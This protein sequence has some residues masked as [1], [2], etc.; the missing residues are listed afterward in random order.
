MPQ[1]AWDIAAVI[2][3]AVTYAATLSSAGGVYFLAY[4]GDLLR[5]AEVRRIKRLVMLLMLVAIVVSCLRIAILTGSMSGELSGMVDGELASVLL[6]GGEGMATGLR[7][8]GLSL[9]GLAFFSQRRR[10]ALAL[11]GAT[12]AAASFAAIGHV[13]AIATAWLSI[14]L[15]GFHLLCVAFWLGALAPL[16]FVAQSDDVRYIAAAASRFGHIAVGIVAALIVT[17][18]TVLYLL[19]G[20][21]SALATS[22]YGH[23][24]VVKLGLVACLLG[25]AAVNKLRITPKLLAGDYT[26]ARNL[27]RSIRIE[28]IVGAL[29]L[30]VTATFTTVTGPPSVG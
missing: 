5:V 2:A 26:A 7:I 25:L 30:M 23:A 3:K 17:G 27:R 18:A 28:I 19:V 10:S 12:A 24:V 16:F 20:S 13:H 21:V 4:S 9:A 1:T 29:I 6:G 22:G 14:G 11:L 8:A 15:L